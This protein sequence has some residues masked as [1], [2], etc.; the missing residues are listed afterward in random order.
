MAALPK[1]PDAYLAARDRLAQ[2][3]KFIL[4]QMEIAGLITADQAKATELPDIAETSTCAPPSFFAPRKVGNEIPDPL[5]PPRQ[6]HG[7]QNR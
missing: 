7:G 3:A 4:L 1:A 5:P 2:R 6:P